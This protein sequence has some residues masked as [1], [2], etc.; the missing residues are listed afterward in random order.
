MYG[1]PQGGQRHPS[2]AGLPDH[3]NQSA[4]S[5]R[6]QQQRNEPY[7]TPQL[8]PLENHGGGLPR[9]DPFFSAPYQG[10]ALSSGQGTPYQGT[11]AQ[12]T[13]YNHGTHLFPYGESPLLAPHPNPR[14]LT[15]P[16]N[17]IN[18]GSPY[19]M[20]QGSPH[21]QSA[22]TNSMMAQII[23]QMQHLTENSN[24]QTDQNTMVND[25]LKKVLE[26]LDVVEK[27]MAE[28]V[29]NEPMNKGKSTDTM[30]KNISNMH[31]IL[32]TIIH[33][34]FFQLCGVEASLN[35]A[36]Q[37]EELLTIEPL[38]NGEPCKIDSNVNAPFIQAVMDRVWNDEMTIRTN[39]SGQGEIPDQAFTR[40]IITKCVKGYWRNIH[41]QCDER[42]SA[43]KLEKA[44]ERKDHGRHRSRC[45]NVTKSRRKAAMQFEEETGNLGA[46]ATIDTD[47]A[48]DILSCGESDLSD[49]SKMRQQEA[50]VGKNANRVVGFQWRSVDYVVFLRFLTLKSMKELNS[51][52]AKDVAVDPPT[53]QDDAAAATADKAAEPTMERPSK[54]RKTVKRALTRPKKIH[55][56]VWDVAPDKL[57]D[58]KPSSG[59]KSAPFANMVSD[60]WKE[61]HPDMKVLEGVP[62]LKGFYEQMK[63]SDDIIEEDCTYLQELDEWH[64]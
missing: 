7:A 47:F 4:E 29:E 26:R 62:W 31:P 11:S 15:A 9:I 42:S 21:E 54:H 40:P 18:A 43:H 57:S 58:R 52:S 22:N 5:Q 38:E 37:V 24:Q 35:K 64:L 1:L 33:P 63:E 36:M 17:H 8:S 44:K 32:K 6:Q 60:K 34:I 59:K 51:E 28:M 41:K 49:D 10:P 20:N 30:G 46:V 61:E 53:V 19:G 2:G 14:G 50:G 25:C 56:K 13:P 39:S 45:Q 55:K 23:S 48:S 27:K 12:G 16:W 3:N